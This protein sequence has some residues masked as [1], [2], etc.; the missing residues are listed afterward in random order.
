MKPSELMSVIRELGLELKCDNG[1]LVL[2]GPKVPERFALMRVLKHHREELLSQVRPPAPPP[3]PPIIHWL[4]PSGEVLH[5]LID[6]PKGVPLR[7]KAWQLAGET[8][9]RAIE[10]LPREWGLLIPSPTDCMTASGL[11]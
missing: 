11:N 2:C 4:M 8:E 7:A 5:R 3:R 9:W 10:T 6:D 1:K